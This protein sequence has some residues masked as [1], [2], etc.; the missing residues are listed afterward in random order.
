MASN[1][2]GGSLAVLRHRVNEPEPGIPEALHGAVITALNEEAVAGAAQGNKGG[3]NL[4]VSY[5]AFAVKMLGLIRQEVIFARHQRVLG[6]EPRWLSV[7][8]VVTSHTWEN[9]KN[10][11]SHQDPTMGEA[12][13]GEMSDTA[14]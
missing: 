14:R 9:S 11:Q 2:M 5:E 10:E 6:Q 3:L 1:R 8:L 7:P 13:L 12:L 4:I